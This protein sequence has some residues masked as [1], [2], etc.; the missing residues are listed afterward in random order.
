MLFIL[1]EGSPHLLISLITIYVFFRSLEVH[2]A[3]ARSTWRQYFTLGEIFKKY[4]NIQESILHLR[5]ALEL[6]PHHDKILSA[7]DE[8][9][10]IPMSTLHFYTILIILLLVICVLIVMRYLNQDEN[11]GNETEAK[12]KRCFKIRGAMSKVRVIR[13]K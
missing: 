13:R 10:K 8:I 5:H 9:E 1:L 7:L 4:G 11:A 3:D 2:N 12:P 6:S